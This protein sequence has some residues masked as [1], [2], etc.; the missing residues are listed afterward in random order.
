MGIN[1]IP[2][3]ACTYSCSY[4]QVGRTIH[5]EIDRRLFYQPD[6]LLKD[7]RDKVEMTRRKK[8]P[9]D[10]LTFVPDGE[11][12]LDINLGLAISLLRSLG[13]KIGVITNGSLLW[14]ED[15]RSDLMNADWVSVK[16]DSVI[17]KPWY[18]LNRPHRTLQLETLLDGIVKFAN[19]FKGI[20]ATET[21]LVRDINDTTVGIEAVSDF[22][23]T[24]K[25]D[26]SYLA[27]PLRPPAEKR[28]QP[29]SEEIVNRAYQ[30]LSRKQT[31]VEL[32]IGYEGNSF[33]STGNAREDLLGITAVHPMRRDAVENFLKRSSAE[34]ALID[35]LIVHG[36]L[37]E[38]EHGGNIFYLRK[39]R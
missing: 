25:P 35:D 9:I 23:A 1:N 31:P 15:V 11:P 5:K 4:C 17:E 21:M 33:A 28:G 3:K 32:L 30:Q 29:P 19:E 2:H 27:I 6:D 8:E 12:T 20:L 16:V 37:V 22:L 26:I 39:F 13:I 36:D 24:L 34:W 14:R 18:M 10:Y 38:T 7:V